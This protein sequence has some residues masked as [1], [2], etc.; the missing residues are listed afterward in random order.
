[1]SVMERKRRTR[2]RAILV[3]SLLLLCTADLG[4]AVA[5]PVRGREP[6]LGSGRGKSVLLSMKISR[7]KKRTHLVTLYK[8][9][10]RQRKAL[11]TCAPRP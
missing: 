8:S 9:V 10:A 7:A 2:N 1:M 4:P 3:A 11:S 5:E 6:A